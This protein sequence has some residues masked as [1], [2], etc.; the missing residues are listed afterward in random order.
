L[1]A[2]RCPNWIPQLQIAARPGYV[3]PAKQIGAHV[4][5]MFAKLTALMNA[6]DKRGVG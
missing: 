1:R 2:V 5:Q 6:L 3:Q 4:D